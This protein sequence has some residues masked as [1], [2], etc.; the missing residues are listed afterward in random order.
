MGP[1]STPGIS[2]MQEWLL[3]IWKVQ[4]LTLHLD[5]KKSCISHKTH[6]SHRLDYSKGRNDYD[7]KK[8]RPQR[9]YKEM[10]VRTYPLAT[11]IGRRS[12]QGQQGIS[13]KNMCG[14]EGGCP[15]RLSPVCSLLSY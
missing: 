9:K 4:I 12:F 14:R 11:S 8:I 7:F 3:L 5:M 2:H 13:S 1:N 6:K 10:L 15:S